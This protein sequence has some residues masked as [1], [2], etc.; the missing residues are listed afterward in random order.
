MD[1]QTYSGT[2]SFTQN[3]SE[4]T[5]IFP[6]WYQALPYKQSHR[7]ELSDKQ[8]SQNCLDFGRNSHIWLRQIIVLY[9]PCLV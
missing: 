2:N 7:I 1:E 4:G 3:S 8:T 5:E 6:N 9:T